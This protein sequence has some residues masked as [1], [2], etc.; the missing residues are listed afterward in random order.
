VKI[1]I[2]LLV[3]ASYYHHKHLTVRAG[4]AVSVNM[5]KIW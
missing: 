3:T 5:L 2:L 1:G 4:L